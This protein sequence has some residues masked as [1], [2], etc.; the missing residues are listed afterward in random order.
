MGAIYV[1]ERRKMEKGERKPRFRVVAISD[2]KIKF[3]ADHLRK[4]E[5]EEIAKLTGA[6]LVYL[7]A[8]GEGKGGGKTA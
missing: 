3:K 7:P 1:R 4:L 6:E 8:D 2:V 5:L